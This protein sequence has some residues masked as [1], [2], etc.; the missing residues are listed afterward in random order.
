MDRPGLAARA[1]LKGEERQNDGGGLDRLAA[2]RKVS[3]T[4]QGLAGWPWLRPLA[5]DPVRLH[6]GPGAWKKL[7]YRL[8]LRPSSIGDVEPRGAAAGV[9]LGPS[10]GRKLTRRSALRRLDLQGRG[11]A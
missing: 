10:G 7:G 5:I 8:A 9:R 3:V 11:D 1:A 4:A 2:A 6:I